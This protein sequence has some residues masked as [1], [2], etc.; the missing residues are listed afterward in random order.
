MIKN[1]FWFLCFLN[2]FHAYCFSQD[3][4]YPTIDESDLPG[5]KFYTERTYT[6][7]SLFG[8]ING[9]AELYREYGLSGAW[10]SEIFLNERKFTVEIY[11]M[12]GPEEAF[13]IFSVSRFRCNSTPLLSPFTCQTPYQLQIV[14]G[15]FYI[16]IINNSGSKS[17]S[18]VLLKIGESIV[19]KVKQVP[20]DIT[21]YLPNV[22]PEIINLQAFL[23]K[24]D[25][26]VM[27]GTPDLADFFGEAKGYTGVVLRQED[28][29][30]VS[31]K[32]SGRE[33]ML[34]FTSQHKW[35]MQEGG[36]EMVYEKTTISKIAED[37]L[38][39]TIRNR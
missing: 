20:A 36:K 29:T 8:Y 18:L 10:V 1:L 27:N 38:L 19:K 12:N 23:V 15:H 24:G 3:A 28:Q 37:H 35:D 11:R 2:F 14:A 32:F 21:G 16:S 39:I 34:A 30:I 31:I 26:G 22:S 6:S 25:L 33:D 7:S 17:D 4:A 5:A 13:G 9:G